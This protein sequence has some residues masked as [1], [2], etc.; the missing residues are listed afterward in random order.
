M[1]SIVQSRLPAA[2]L[3]IASCMLAASPALAQ[4]Q[5]FQLV[6]TLSPPGS[7]TNPALWQPVNRYGFVNSTSA[8]ESLTQIPADQ[9]FDPAGVTFRTATELLVGNRHGNALGQGSIGRFTLSS[10]G[11]TITPAGSITHPGMIGVHELAVSPVTGDLF[12]AAVNN[13]IFQFRFDAQGNAIFV[14]HF[15]V[16]VPIRGLHVHPGGQFIYATSASNLIRIYR[17]NESGG[18]DTLPPVALAGAVN[19]HYFCQGPAGNEVFVSDIDS[20]RVT[21]FRTLPSGELVQL[22][23]INSVSPIDCAFSLDGQELFVGSH[24]SGG[25]RRYRY[26]PTADTWQ[27]VSP[28]G[29]I[30]T[31]P[32]GGFAS[33]TVPPCGEIDLGRQGG[34]LGADGILDNNDFIIFINLFFDQDPRVDVGVEGGARGS[35]GQF[36]NNDF[37]V[38][39]NQFFFGCFGAQP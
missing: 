30:T 8:P 39:V 38:F 27:F 34:E 2:C 12:A 10:D 35:D 24:F 37:I 26:N 4:P 13:G 28:N 14:R 18:V 7:N 1:S 36:D 20:G 22:G 3:V 19:L 21:R 11:S 17:L 5:S 23:V 31:P 15:A 32:L 33:Y 6:V 16:G 9:V 25:I 29:L